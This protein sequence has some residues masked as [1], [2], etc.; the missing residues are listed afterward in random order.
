MIPG[1]VGGYRYRQF[2]IECRWNFNWGE[3][4][5]IRQ[6]RVVWRVKPRKR[7]SRVSGD[8]RFFDPR[9]NRPG[10]ALPQ[11]GKPLN[12]KLAGAYFQ[13]EYRM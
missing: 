9:E 3:C 13:F 4:A 8:S 6:M 11:P 2:L 5:E 10:H 7:I 12:I 1:I